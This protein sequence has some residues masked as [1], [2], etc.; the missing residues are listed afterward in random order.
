MKAK[1]RL[2]TFAPWLVCTT[3]NTTLP[4]GLVSNL[5]TQKANRDKGLCPSLWLSLRR[6]V[7]SIACV[8]IVLRFTQQGSM[9]KH[10][11]Y[12]TVLL[13]VDK[14]LQLH[15]ACSQR[16]GVI[17]VGPSGSGKS[18]TWRLLQAALASLGRPLILHVVNPKAISRHHLLGED[19]MPKCSCFS[20]KQRV[21]AAPPCLENRL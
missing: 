18:T 13:Q 11:L 2:H 1:A 10:V 21:D 19:S 5:Y 8:T 3:G 15:L 14:V 6:R 9:R 17:I 7:G 16:I 12:R 20:M 4:G